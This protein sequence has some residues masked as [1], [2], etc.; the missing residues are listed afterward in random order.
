MYNKTN[1]RSK[2]KYND[3]NYND[4]FVHIFPRKTLPI[5]HDVE[6][7]PSSSLGFAR[8]ILVRLQQLAERVHPES[9]CGFSSGRSI[10]QLI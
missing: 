1:S 2:E 3:C 7:T 4:D 6:E 8:V 9:Q 10:R 5:V